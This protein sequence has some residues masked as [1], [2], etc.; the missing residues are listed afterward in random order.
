MGRRRR[1]LDRRRACTRLGHDDCLGRRLDF[2]G[3][4]LENRHCDGLLHLYR[5]GTTTDIVPPCL[6]ANVTSVNITGRDNIDDVLTVDF[7]NGNPMPAG[8]LNFNGGSLGSGSGNSL[9]II[10]SS[11]DENAVLSATQITGIGSAPINYSNTTFFSFHLGG[12][13]DSLLI[14]NNATLKINEDN[15]ISAAGTNITID[16]GVLDLN[17]KTDTIGDLLLKS[18]SIV[19][20]TLTRRFIYH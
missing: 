4:D 11:G 10:G 6:R 1:E 7:S 3:P 19:N 20:G 16:N 13:S 14:N 2:D 17:G 12:G 8:G 18:G 9:Y 15:A 5:T